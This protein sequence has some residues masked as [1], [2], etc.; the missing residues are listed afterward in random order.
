MYLKTLAHILVSCATLF[1][2]YE[3]S[4]RMLGEALI[5]RSNWP[6]LYLGRE[7]I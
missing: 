5:K 7:L 1:T 4:S 6:P 3:I 2:R